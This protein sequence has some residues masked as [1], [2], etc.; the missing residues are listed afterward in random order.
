M[1][2]TSRDLTCIVPTKDRPQKV[3]NL[4]D[5]L[6]K[7][8]ALPG[9]VLIIDGGHSVQHV[10]NSFSDRLLVERHPCHPPGQ[11]RQ[12]NLGISM[13]DKA[14]KLVAFLD[15]DLELEPDAIENMIE[16]WNRVE[17]ETAGI[18]FN[19]VNER[20]CRN[21]LLDYLSLRGSS[22]PGVVL[23]SGANTSFAHLKKE[24]RVQ[25]LGG[26]Y[27]VWR[28]AILDIYPQNSIR[29]S[30]AIG[31][32][33]RF[34]YPIGKKY[35]LYACAA[36][37]VRHEHVID[38][39]PP[40]QVFRYRGYKKVVAQFYFVSQNQELSRIACLWTLAT[41]VAAALCRGAFL[42]EK[43]VIQE[44][45]GRATAFGSCLGALFGFTDLK[46]ALED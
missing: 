31:E 41:G 24:T 15:D 13:L 32:D 8:T 44:S 11:I 22:C 45:L 20:P 35:P 21:S 19:V 39:V 4:L 3:A 29:T 43:A 16:L 7:Q 10:V 25:W 18:G 1:T 9:R 26:G 30:W 23:C 2:Y 14:A 5:T 28:K 42:R 40:A 17:S 37:R 6:A 34:S 27:T 36:A 46:K 12:R 33:L 38:Q